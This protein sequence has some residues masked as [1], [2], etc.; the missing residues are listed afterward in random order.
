M[1]FVTQVRSLA[2]STY[3]RNRRSA[4]VRPIGAN[5]WKLEMDGTGYF[6]LGESVDYEGDSKGRSGTMVDRLDKD[7]LR[8]AVARSVGA[9]DAPGTTV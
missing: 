7:Y 6:P 5:Q 9:N 8:V 1:D 3:T 2:E 4:D